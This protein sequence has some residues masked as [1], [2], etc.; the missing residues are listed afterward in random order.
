MD[1]NNKNDFD[2]SFDRVW[3]HRIKILDEYQEYINSNPHTET[4]E[5]RK[6]IIKKL[7]Q[8]QLRLETTQGILTERKN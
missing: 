8:F 4:L 7:K 5:D 3:E 2:E 6:K 1:K